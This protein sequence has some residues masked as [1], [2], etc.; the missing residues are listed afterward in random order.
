MS[1]EVFE[2]LRLNHISEYKTHTSNYKVADVLPHKNMFG[3]KVSATDGTEHGYK[4]WF[5]R[6][7]FDAGPNLQPLKRHPRSFRVCHCKIV[8]LEDDALFLAGM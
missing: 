7:A 2:S 8:V 1:L 4:S 5:S 6:L 3:N